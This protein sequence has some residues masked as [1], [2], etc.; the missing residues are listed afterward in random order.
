MHIKNYFIQIEEDINN[1]FKNLKIF[2]AQNKKTFLILIFVTFLCYGF[3]IANFT[4]SID[5]EY[6]IKNDGIS[7][8]GWLAQS[9]YTTFLLKSI[10]NSSEVVPFWTTFLSVAILFLSTIF[11]IFTIDRFIPKKKGKLTT[12]IFCSLIISSPINVFF[13][14]FSTYNIEVALGILLTG[15]SVY[16][17]SETYFFIKNK[18]NLFIGILFLIL[19]L[20]IYQ[21]F[22]FLFILGVLTCWFIKIYYFN[23]KLDKQSIIKI[24]YQILYTVFFALVFYLFIN[25]FSQIFVNKSDY[26]N[27]FWQWPNKSFYQ[28]Y[29]E[30]RNFFYDIA[31]NH[32]FIFGKVWLLTFLLLLTITAY[33]L[34]GKSQNN[35][36]LKI[37]IL[38]CIASSPV[39]FNAMFG[40]ILPFRANQTL[41]YFIAVTWLLSL[42]CF[43]NKYIKLFLIICS[44]FIIFLQSREINQFFFFDNLRYQRDIATAENINERLSYLDVDSNI[45]IYF[46]GK[47]VDTFNKN[48]FKYETLGYSFFEWDNG[49]N[50]RMRSFLNFRGYS[51]NLVDKTQI[52]PLEAS[53]S[54]MPTWP[55]K[56]SIKIINDIAI[57]KLSK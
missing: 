7:A 4:L 32:T 33:I 56:N 22:L 39:I 44:M 38:F 16:F 9:R 20:G 54:A 19:S 18:T 45:K 28:F 5:E 41:I 53:I 36:C 34:F 15:I 55:D 35:K 50:Y 17:V 48:S 26:L 13:I 6:G 37:I 57:I 24:I 2:F 12:F 3:E 42:I 8:K 25:Y 40:S 43:K 52:E 11:W 30:M 31:F 51:Y 23:K 1:I 21:S 27:G 47:L 46:F 14:S 10:F 49:N 29:L